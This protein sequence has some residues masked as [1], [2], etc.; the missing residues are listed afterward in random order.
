MNLPILVPEERIN[1]FNYYWQDK[2]NFGIV[3]HGRIYA[4]TDSFPQDERIEAY[5]KGCQLAED[6]DVVITVSKGMRPQY[7]LWVSPSG[8][9]L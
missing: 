5:D 2:V 1:P 7:Q 3:M 4:L 9:F 8:Y 6:H